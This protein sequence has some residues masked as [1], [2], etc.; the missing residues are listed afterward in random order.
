MLEYHH[1]NEILPAIV[2]GLDL[3]TNDNVLAIC[4][5]GDQAFAISEYVS[6]VT[7]ID[8]DSEQI[9]Y[10]R[11]RVQMLKT[12]DLDG[13]IDHYDYGYEE[14]FHLRNK[15][16]GENGRLNKIRSKIDK[17]NFENNNLKA[18]N[19]SGFTK[20]YLSNAVNIR[21]STESEYLELMENLETTIDEGSLVYISDRDHFKRAYD[22][23]LYTKSKKPKLILDKNL[24]E[25]ASS[26]DLTLGVRYDLIPCVYMKVE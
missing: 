19:F 25:E 26:R 9:R 23:F 18:K 16:F 8:Y 10:A 17:I 15:Y 24:S 1:T 14:Y 6:D 22:Y 21:V 20:L 12:G 13:F 4:S 7:A 11:L 3:K 2:A 5:S